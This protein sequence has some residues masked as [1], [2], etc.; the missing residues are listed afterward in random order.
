MNQIYYPYNLWE[1]YKN[2]MYSVIFLDENLLIDNATKVLSSKNLFDSICIE[3]I[4]A[5][6]ISAA[7]NLTN[8]SC[9]RRAWLGQAACCFKYSVPEILTRVAWNKLTADQQK[10]ANLVAEKHITNYE[11]KFKTHGKNQTTIECF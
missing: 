9:N 4:T 8:I 3:L 10:I 2:G 1:D 7:V 11:N 6:P 5:W